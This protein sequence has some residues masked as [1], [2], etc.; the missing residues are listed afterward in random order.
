MCGAVLRKGSRGR[1][2]VT[3]PGRLGAPLTLGFLPP[4]PREAS[5]QDRL[6]SVRFPTP[7]LYTLPCWLLFSALTARKLYDMAFA[8][9][10]TATFRVTLL[11][12]PVS[13]APLSWE[14]ELGCQVLMNSSNEP[15]M[16]GLI[17][18]KSLPGMV[19][20]RG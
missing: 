3:G 4:P 16:K 11:P 6:F 9:L 18:R 8:Y 12:Y 19:Q 13:G 20:A 7:A 2:R 5:P 17:Q 1:F 15:K 14:R 10:T